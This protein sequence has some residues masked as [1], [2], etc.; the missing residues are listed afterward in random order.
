MRDHPL[1]PEIRP[2]Q[3]VVQGTMPPAQDHFAGLVLLGRAI[4]LMAKNRVH[5]VDQD[6]KVL[7]KE[8]GVRAAV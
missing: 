4:G 5:P 6:K 7:P 1:A 3:G 2:A 8:V